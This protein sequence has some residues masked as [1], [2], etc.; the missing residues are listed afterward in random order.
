M[1]PDLFNCTS[2]AF[3]ELST[4]LESLERNETELN[5]IE[6]K[7]LSLRL[8]SV[9]DN[10]EQYFGNDVHITYRLLSHL[11]QFENRQEGFGL[12]ATQDAQ[13]TENLLRAGSSV[14]MLSNREHW[15]TL[16]HTERG[17]AGLM[18]LF[19]EYT[20]TLA[21][22]MK[23]T[24]LNPVGLV[25]PNIVVN[26]ERVDNQIPPRRHFPRYHSSL[27]RGQT[28]W[29]PHT[30]V[31]LPAS[32]LKPPKVEAPPT[33]LPTPTNSENNLTTAVPP[34]KRAIPDPEPAATILVLLVYRTLGDLLPAKC[35]T[36]KRNL[37]L[38][39]NPVMN[40]PIVS[41]AI[42]RDQT[43]IYGDLEA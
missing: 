32:V 30:H 6:A 13:F 23:L 14:L 29:D 33:V 16:L 5:T 27:F 8:R 9:T 3:M 4:L 18:E 20:G 15:E 37:R 41:V 35:S 7:K 43:F 40:S 12:T 36:D 1:E 22:N 34:P 19:R 42:L 17:S 26:I 10:M 31:V 28:S 38:P 25:T 24:Y 39:K 11:M 2:P 21:R